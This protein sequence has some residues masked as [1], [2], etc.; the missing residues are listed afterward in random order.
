M[1]ETH[2][3][4]GWKQRYD[5]EE[6][7]SNQSLCIL[8]RKTQVWAIQ[9]KYTMTDLVVASGHN[10]LEHPSACKK[11]STFWDKVVAMVWPQLP[12]LALPA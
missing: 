12:V 8:E 3:K 11:T 2:L 7:M 5:S 6:H 1:I 4:Y 9:K 10:T